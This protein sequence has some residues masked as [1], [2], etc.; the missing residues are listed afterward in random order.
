MLLLPLAFAAPPAPG[1]IPAA[2]VVEDGTLE[3]WTARTWSRSLGGRLLDAEAVELAA[4]PATPAA[5]PDG[6]AVA[7]P[8]GLDVRDS[9]GALRCSAHLAPGWTTHVASGSGALVATA[10]G[11]LLALI[12]ARDCAVRAAVDTIDGTPVVVGDQVVVIAGWGW[13][14]HQLSDLAPVGGWRPGGGRYDLDAHDGLTLLDGRRA[15]T[16]DGPTQMSP[17]PGDDL[18]R[19]QPVAG[20]VVRLLRGPSGPGPRLR[21]HPQGVVAIDL[22]TGRDLGLPLPVPANAGATSADGRLAITRTGAH[23]DAWATATAE[24]RWGLDAPELIEPV[25]LRVDSG[26]VIVRD[27]RGHLLALRAT[28]GAVL[29]RAATVQ[30]GELTLA[31][32]SS[33]AGTWRP[34]GPAGTLDAPPAW[35][36]AEPALPAPSPGGLADDAFARLD[37]AGADDLSPRCDVDP[38]VLAPFPALL[39]LE[40]ARRAWACA[41][42]PAPTMNWPTAAGPAPA[43]TRPVPL[44]TLPHEGHTPAVV[45]VWGGPQDVAALGSS[46]PANLPIEWRKDD[47]ELGRQRW[48]PSGSVEDEVRSLLHDP[49]VRAGPS[50]ADPRPAGSA[51]LRAPDG[52]VLAQGTVADVR[53][54]L[55]GFALDQVSGRLPRAVASPRWRYAAPDP[56][57]EVQALGGGEV[58]FHT[59]EAI[60]VLDA[61]GRLRWNAT[62]HA[63]ELERVGDLLL[64][65]RL[66]QQTRAYDIQTGTV[67][68][69]RPA[70]DWHHTGAL[71]WAWNTGDVGVVAADGA[72]RA[73]TDVERAALGA[74][75]VRLRVGLLDCRRRAGDGAWRGCSYG[76]G[77]PDGL[78]LGDLRVEPDGSAWVA[79]R[80]DGAEAWRLVVGAEPARLGAA[81][82]D[83]LIVPLGSWGGPWALLGRDGRLRQWLAPATDAS[84]DGRDAF[85]VTDGA[86]VAWRTR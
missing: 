46:R 2:R 74:E 1:P 43:A 71:L 72:L 85:L 84:I 25:S 68:W 45:T 66:H 64:A 20:G 79:R 11:G 13:A 8:G 60:G 81:S 80:A 53:R 41:P 31:E 22:S 4:A 27:S 10:Q 24:H 67:R 32:L 7:T 3:L 55:T 51:E 6:T 9:D 14:I 40:D 12:D 21:V 29:L 63:D 26:G 35:E 65:T 57:E 59:Q 82:G 76:S 28:D 39:A 58:A 78:P 38:A 54:A 73:P 77:G 36:G 62:F 30:I 47:R 69:T 48:G 23:L 42:E 50:F 56:I 33:A 19:L 44:A 5:L 70:L 83:R 52:T 34:E 16:A 15:W 17:P 61:R 75:E 37:L 18:P 49:Y 86:V